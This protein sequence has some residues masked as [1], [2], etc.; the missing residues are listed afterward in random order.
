MKRP[1]LK[2]IL[3]V[4]LTVLLLFGVLSDSRQVTQAAAVGLP[5]TDMACYRTLNT[6]N[7]RLTELVN[8]YPELAE[9]VDIGDSWEMTDGDDTTPGS[10][11]WVLHLTNRAI[12][13]AK[14]IMFV[15]SGADSRDI[16]GVELNLRFAE[17]LLAGYGVDPDITMVLGVSEVHLL[18]TANPDGRQELEWQ[19]ALDPV[20]TFQNAWGHNRNINVCPGGVDL[21]RNFTLDYQSGT[22]CGVDYTGTGAESEPETQAIAGHMR[23]IYADLRAAP[24]LPVD[25]SAPG[26]V[27]NLTEWDDAPR[28]L[29][30]YYYDGTA[31]A[32]DTEKWIYLL[33]AKLAN[34]PG[35]SDF[36]WH[37]LGFDNDSSQ[38]GSLIDTAYGELGVPALAFR[39]ERSIYPTKFPTCSEFEGVDNIWMEALLMASRAVPRPFEFGQGPEFVP[40][41]YVKS[42]DIPFRQMWEVRGTAS[43]LYYQNVPVEKLPSNPIGFSATKI[44]PPWHSDAVDTG[45]LF[46][47]FPP[48][49]H[50]AGFMALVPFEA[51]A[52]VDRQSVYFQAS[53]LDEKLGIPRAVFV[54]RQYYLTLPLIRR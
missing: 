27:I 53:N 14:P 8:D 18:V 32:D 54:T 37:Q 23:A 52:G 2:N 5:G 29:Y 21:T 1:L 46:L 48:D 11:L 38:R 45:S 20:L 13:G 26:L 12:T 33:A 19:L 41:L 51:P 39:L 10:D 24:D 9:L 34:V 50:T 40:G 4:G 49:P 42:L 44:T 16:M 7:S 36:F 15:V 28:I 25:E 3:A 31:D 17:R 43:S 35:S 30:P 6:I 22:F 47:E